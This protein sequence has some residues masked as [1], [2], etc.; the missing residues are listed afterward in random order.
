M[1][2][3]GKEVS[4][5][6]SLELKKYVDKGEFDNELFVIKLLVADVHNVLVK[7]AK[8][9]FYNAEYATRAMLAQGINQEKLDGLY[10]LIKDIYIDAFMDLRRKK[11]KDSDELIAEVRNRINEKNST[12]LSATTT[13]QIINSFQKNGML[14]QLANKLDED[15]WWAIDHSIEHIEE[16]RREKSDE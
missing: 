9:S 10:I 16:F 6:A 14:H 1:I 15:I 12:V 4:L 8:E 7:S 5:K 11:L 2:Q 3:F 13:H